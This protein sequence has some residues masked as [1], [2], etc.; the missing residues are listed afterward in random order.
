M[1]WR[2]KNTVIFILLLLFLFLVFTY[3]VN[4][5]KIKTQNKTRDNLS[6]KPVVESQKDCVNKIEDRLVRGNSLSGLIEPGAS[7]K[8]LFGFYDCHEIKAGDIIAYNYSGNPEPLIKI[9][10][11]VPGDKFQLKRSSDDQNINILINGEIIKNSQNQP[12]LLDTKGYKMLSL[13][14]KDYK[15]IIP[16]DT[17]LILGNLAN[18]SLD[19]AH[20]GLIDKSDIL[21]K[22]E[23]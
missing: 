16:K 17:Y 11:A 23:F 6:D 21:G 15:G 12:Y 14:E 10:R 20:F 22:V 1:I 9:V 2:F 7:V 19:S 18:G 5:N 4:Q 3:A 13:Y 8:I